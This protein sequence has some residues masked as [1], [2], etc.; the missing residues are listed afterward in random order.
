MGEYLSKMAIVPI[1][2]FILLAINGGNVFAVVAR[3]IHQLVGVIFN[4]GGNADWLCRRMAFRPFRHARH[5]TTI[6]NA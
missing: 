6:K 2:F 3:G 5:Q 4:K 1:F